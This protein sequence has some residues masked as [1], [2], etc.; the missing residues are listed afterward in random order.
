MIYTAGLDHPKMNLSHI[1]FS[2]MDYGYELN[3]Q[4][5][6]PQ[7]ET[8]VIDGFD[9]INLDVFGD[10]D[11]P[12]ANDF[13]M[14]IGAD[15]NYIRPDDVT[16]RAVGRNEALWDGP[17]TGDD[18]V[19]SMENFNG[20]AQHIVIQIVAGL[21]FV[22]N[23]EIHN[24]P[25]SLYSIVAV[26]P[27]DTFIRI[28][29][30]D[31]NQQKMVLYGREIRNRQMMLLTHIMGNVSAISSIRQ[32]HGVND[33]IKKLVFLKKEYLPHLPGI[34]V[35]RIIHNGMPTNA[36]IGIRPGHPLDFARSVQEIFPLVEV[37]G[38][39]SGHCNTNLASQFF[40]KPKPYF[41]ILAEFQDGRLPVLVTGFGIDAIMFQFGF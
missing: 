6:V 41:D 22:R 18:F 7:E 17:I 16:D 4:H 2:A 38:E 10:L 35:I 3:A 20:S 32:V 8:P 31:S 25:S 26:L 28:M 19:A 23:E 9:N 36:V 12:T 37:I 24:M 30:L 13:I 11:G 27:A 40:T 14:A 5:F 33:R 21:E 1:N 34:Y 39:R 29:H 15:D